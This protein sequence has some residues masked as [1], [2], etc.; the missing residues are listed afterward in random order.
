MASALPTWLLHTVLIAVG[1]AS[2]ALL[3]GG[4]NVVGKRQF[5]EVGWPV[6]TFAANA[7]GCL[8]I[9]VLH[10]VL[11]EKFAERPELRSALVVGLLGALTTFSTYGLEV[12]LLAE[13][14]RLLAATGYVLLS[15]AVGIGLV[16]LGL[17]LARTLVQ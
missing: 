2:G 10:V 3:R 12:A 1:G 7:L 13:D 5:A 14:R 9:G 8:A 11:T 15:N 6:A 4:L 16:V 17:R